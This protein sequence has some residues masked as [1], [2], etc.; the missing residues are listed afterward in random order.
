MGKVVWYSVVMIIALFFSCKAET[1]GNLSYG[2]MAKKSDDAERKIQYI[3]IFGER[4]SGTNFLTKLIEKNLEV[5]LKFR[6]GWKH[7]PCWYDTPFEN[8]ISPTQGRDYCTL[9]G[10]ENFLFIVIVRD[11]Y[12]WLRSFFLQPF[13]VSHRVPRTRFYSFIRSRW[14]SGDEDKAICGPAGIYDRD[15]ETNGYFNNILHLRSARIEN[16]LKLMHKAENV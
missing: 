7:F 14:Y 3:Q 16:F 12:D 9:E 13:H 2:I 4:C 6:Y 5:P 11:P 15:P 8:R 1:V 10:N